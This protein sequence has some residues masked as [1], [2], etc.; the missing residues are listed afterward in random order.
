MKKIL[1]S[2]FVCSNCGNEF[3]KWS[4]QCSACHEW[5]TLK[6]I[7]NLKPKSLNSKRRENTKTEIKNL[8]SLCQGSGMVKEKNNNIFSTEIKE[9]DRVLGKGI[10]RGQVI[11]FA[12]EPGIGKS[13]L[14]TQLVGKIGGLYVAAE[15]TVE[16]INLRVERLGLDKNK[17]DILDNAITGEQ[18][19][20]NV[21]GNLYMR[22]RLHS[23][24]GEIIKDT[25]G[26]SASILINADEASNG[27]KV[28]KFITF[29]EE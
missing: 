6:E 27:I 28:Y 21:C 5:N 19:A 26:P 8:A 25:V 13:T 4:G 2:I 11:L 22:K 29:M 20:S 15:E 7:K 1:E 17:F 12:G 18:I 3:S 24:Y 14:L 9:F 10:V 16:Q 23:G